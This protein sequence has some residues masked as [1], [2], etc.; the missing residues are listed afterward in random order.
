MANER[1]SKAT[2]AKYLSDRIVDLEKR[3]GID[4][5]NGT[6]QCIGKSQEFCLAYGAYRALDDAMTA[7]DLAWPK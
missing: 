4:P 3:H 7:L 1:F 5:D 2:V 6:S